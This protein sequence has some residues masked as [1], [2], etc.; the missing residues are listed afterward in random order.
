MKKY[1]IISLLLITIGIAAYTIYYF[2]LSPKYLA[3]SIMGDMR[4]GKIE[5]Q[6]LVLDKRLDLDQ[7]AD[8]YAVEQNL[9]K[10][11]AQV[12]YYRE[13]LFQIPRSIQHYELIEIQEFDYKSWAVFGISKF[14][15]E[16]NWKLAYHSYDDFYNSVTNLYVNKP[17]FNHNQERQRIEYQRPSKQLRFIYRV[18]TINNILKLQLVF[19]R[20]YQNRW[21]VAAIFSQKI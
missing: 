10:D 8:D 11:D 15:Y 14:D 18:E 1:L 6:W 12:K 4:N 13:M 16:R 3:A 2:V 20:D 21:K 19:I 5:S 9:D 7:F 17:R